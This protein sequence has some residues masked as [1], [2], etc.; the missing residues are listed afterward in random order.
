V[1]GALFAQLFGSVEPSQ[2]DLTVSLMV[3]AAVVLGG[4]WGIAGVIVAAL[5]IAAY[6]R[7]IVDLLGAFSLRQHNYLVFGL[8]LL[9]A[10]LWRASPAG[11]ASRAAGAES[12][13]VIRARPSSR[14]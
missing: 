5:A 7:V 12:P 9:L 13:L 11:I 4:R 3:L 2:F 14:V 6:D 1:A 8:A 10:S